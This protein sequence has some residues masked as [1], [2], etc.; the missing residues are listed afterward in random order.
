MSKTSITIILTIF[1]FISYSGIYLIPQFGIRS[2]HIIIY[3]LFALVSVYFFLLNRPIKVNDSVLYLL[4]F[5][6]IINVVGLIATFSNQNSISIYEILADIENYLQPIILIILAS[7]FVINIK[8]ISLDEQI[9]IV[10]KIFTIFISLNAIFSIFLL[11]VGPNEYLYLIGGLP[12]D[13]GYNV[14]ERALYA[15]RSGGVFSQPI[16]AGIAYSI[17]MIVWLYLFDKNKISIKERPIY[18]VQFLLMIVGGFVSGSKVAY[19]LGWGLSLIYIFF[20]SNIYHKLLGQVKILLTII[21]FIILIY[22]VIQF[23]DG[24][25]NLWRNYYYFIYYKIFEGLS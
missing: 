25:G 13:E 24:V 19:I 17:G 18:V 2:D 8:K 6:I 14:A 20:L 12:D 4:S 3:S 7:Y 22:I 23:W 5:L 21:F 15:H 9:T 16:D 10:S 1:F 11:Y